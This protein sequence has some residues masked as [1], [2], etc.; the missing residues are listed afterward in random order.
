MKAMILAA[1]R[2]QRLRP[3]TDHTPKPL[4]RAGNKS[5]IEYHLEA[6]RNAGF[7][8]VVINVAHLPELIVHTL[9]NGERY[10]LNIRY[11]HE[12]PD[13][14][15]TGGGIFK[16][17][18]LLGQEP[19]LVINGDIWTDYPLQN[20]PEHIE[21]LAHLVLVDNPPHVPQGDYVLSEGYVYLHGQQR[22]TLA[23]INIYHPQLFAHCKPGVFRVPTL[24]N[25]AINLQL[26][27]GEHFQ[28]KWIDVGTLER[29]QQLEDYLAT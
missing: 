11:S 8:E 21:G 6:L 12:M 16:A 15:E 9:G 23:G 25:Q 28:G 3:L 5:L 29:L 17:L 20:L 18:P 14:L 27:T 7:H 10:G 24:I 22:F 19:F 4:L 13:A 1:G 2:G 26:V